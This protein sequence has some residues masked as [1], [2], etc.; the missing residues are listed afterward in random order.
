M[1]FGLVPML[2]I[3]SCTYPYSFAPSPYS[4]VCAIEG[5]RAMEKSNGMKCDIVGSREWRAAER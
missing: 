1:K 2:S 5:N 3:C 4:I